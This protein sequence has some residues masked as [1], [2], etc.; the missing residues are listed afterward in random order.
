M[1]VLVVV[2]V[3]VCV[4]ASVF[5]CVRLLVTCA[6]VCLCV[7]VC[8]FVCVLGCIEPRVYVCVF[9]CLLVREGVC[10]CPSV[11]FCVC[12]FLG[13]LVEFRRAC[14]HYFEAPQLRALDVGTRRSYLHTCMRGAF[15]VCQKCTKRGQ[16]PQALTRINQCPQL[17]LHQRIG[18]FRMHGE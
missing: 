9:V 3:C 18:T 4:C 5:A 10:E 7:C 6:Y 8:V 12:V 2:C 15:E 1:F 14:M 16:P 11:A 17:Q 13:M